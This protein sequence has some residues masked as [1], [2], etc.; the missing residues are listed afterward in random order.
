MKLSTVTGGD[1]D[2]LR[3]VP[4]TVEECAMVVSVAVSKFIPAEATLLVPY[5]DREPWLELRV[6]VGVPRGTQLDLKTRDAIDQTS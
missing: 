5:P 3:L 1:R 4:E 6:W 2:Y